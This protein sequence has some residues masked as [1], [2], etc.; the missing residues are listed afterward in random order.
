[1]YRK[2]KKRRLAREEEKHLEELRR[3]D[4][5]AAKEIEDEA[6]LKRAHERMTLKHK[7]TSKFIRGL[8]KHGGTHRDRTKEAIVDQLKQ[9]EELTMKM[10]TM[11]DEGDEELSSEEEDNAFSVKKNLRKHANNL[12]KEVNDDKA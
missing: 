1:M 11:E 6:A 2:L 12:L 5:K 4:P 7:N 3:I 10:N 9:G 8:L